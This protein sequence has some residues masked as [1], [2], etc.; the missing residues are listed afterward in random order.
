[1]V[2]DRDAAL[3]NLARSEA[4]SVTL[5]VL[6]DL[7]ILPDRRTLLVPSVMFILDPLTDF[8]ASLNVMDSV[9][10]PV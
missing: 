4:P 2:R 1:M 7:D 9:P 8:I 10:L 6:P 3:V 5:M